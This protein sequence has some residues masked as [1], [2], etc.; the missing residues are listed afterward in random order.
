MPAPVIDPSVK[1][2]CYTCGRTWKALKEAHCTAC[3][4]H[5]TSDSAARR[6]REGAYANVSA[7]TPSSRRCIPVERF[8]EPYG[9]ETLAHKLG[10]AVRPPRLVRVERASGPAWAT[11]LRDNAPVEIGGSA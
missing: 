8:T 3:C 1:G 7:G 11:D 9:K 6:H 5:F 4:G 2:A 10:K